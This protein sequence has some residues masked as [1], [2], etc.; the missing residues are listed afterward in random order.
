MHNNTNRYWR[1]RDFYVA[2]YLFARGAVITGIF[3]ENHRPVFSF[4]D[5]PDR[6]DWEDEF[7]FGKPMI[8]ARVLIS[9]ILVLHRKKY[10]AFM[11]SHGE[12]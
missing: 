4:L 12:D 7:R 10:D 6:G 2:A 3:I 9:A 8:D 11:R 1:T 5:S